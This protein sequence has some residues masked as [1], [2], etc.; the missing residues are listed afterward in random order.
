[1]PLRRVSCLRL[2]FL[3]S[4]LVV[5]VGAQPRQA[6]PLAREMLAAHNAVRAQVNVPPLT[7]SR[8]LAARAQDW[9]DFLLRAHR[10]YHRPGSNF[11]ENIFEISGAPAS[12]SQVV[13]DWASEARDYNYRA[14][15][16]RGVCG[17]YTQL[18]WGTTR[19]VGCAVARS[20]GREVWV[21]NYAPHGNWMGERPY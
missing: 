15:T 20:A 3:A 4:A 12:A 16:C 6:T 19:E 10:F 8:K 2:A 14:N 18:V 9:A 7:W 11:G 5:T 13:A 17:H 21:C 1:M